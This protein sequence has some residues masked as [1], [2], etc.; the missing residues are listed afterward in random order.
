MRSPIVVGTKKINDVQFYKKI[1][2]LYDDLDIK[3]ERKKLNYMDEL[4]Q[5]ERER[6]M[7]KKLNAKFHQFVQLI[8]AQAEKGRHKIEFDIPFDGLEFFGCP[9]KSVVKVKPTKNCLIAI[10]E[11]PC[12]VVDISEIEIAYFERVIFGINY[13]DIALVFKD[14]INF[15]RIDSVPIE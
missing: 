9:M 3:N 13:F 5:E 10:S 6:Q 1:D 11:F 14:F 2:A 12:F 7:K 8:E 4:E 15:K